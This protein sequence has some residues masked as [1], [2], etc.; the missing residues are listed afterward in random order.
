MM[1]FITTR[2]HCNISQRRGGCHD[3]RPILLNLVKF[4]YHSNVRDVDLDTIGGE[5]PM[6][7]ELRCIDVKVGAQV[8]K[9]ALYTGRRELIRR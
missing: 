5:E 7:D 1:Q 4:L 8:R 6:L 2:V 3:R 9:G